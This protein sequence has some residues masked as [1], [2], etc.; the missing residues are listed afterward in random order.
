MFG[1]KRRRFEMLVLQSIEELEEEE[2]YGVP[3]QKHL[4]EVIGRH[5]YFGELYAALIRVREKK[6]ILSWA[7][8]G[9]KKR[10][11]RR[12]QLHALT[13]EGRVLLKEWQSTP[14]ASELP[15]P[16]MIQRMREATR[17]LF[18]RAH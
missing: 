13:G 15:S 6:L 16:G 18:H 5:V 14:E 4:S 9:G 17:S 7:V 1:A 11:Y 10:G 12:K 3:L 8:P 2:T